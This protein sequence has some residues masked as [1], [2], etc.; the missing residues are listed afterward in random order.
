MNEVQR[1]EKLIAEAKDKLDEAIEILDNNGMGHAAHT[2]KR[3]LFIHLNA[4]RFN[5][6]NKHIPFWRR[7]LE[8][9][10]RG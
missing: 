7:V 10:A 6:V 4:R 2:M 1:Y 3:Q 5:L 8:A 9:L